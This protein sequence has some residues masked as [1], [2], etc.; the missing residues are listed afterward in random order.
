MTRL[1]ACLLLLSAAQ[2]IAWAQFHEVDMIGTVY[3]DSVSGTNVTIVPQGRTIRW[4]LVSGGQHTV[5][6][7]LGG[8][9]FDSGLMTSA[10]PQFTFTPPATGMINYQCNVHLSCCNM[11]GTIIVIPAL[12]FPGS[13]EDTVLETSVAGAALSID[14]T[15]M[16]APGDTVSIN[17]RSPHGSFTGIGFLI[18]GQLF[19]TGTLP[20]GPTGF[21]S[22]HVNPSITPGPFLLH[23]G[24]INTVLGFQG[25][26]PNGHNLF[27]GF[28]PPGLAGNSLMIQ[29]LSTINTAAN[30]FF[31]ASDGKVIQLTP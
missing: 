23:N 8:M 2:S 4:N 20:G 11:V 1:C 14:E 15:K 22:V 26:P 13:N 31:A 28:V 5:T 27:F 30:G 16:A 6:D 10:N 25:L 3:V 24:T 19:T 17:Y 29:G 7:S 18:V 12:N 9:I 21:P